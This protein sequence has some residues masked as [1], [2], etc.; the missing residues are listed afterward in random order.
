MT[1]LVYRYGLLPPTAGGDLIAEQISRAHQYAHRLTEIERTRRAAVQAAAPADVLALRAEVDA[2]VAALA[3]ARQAIRATRQRTRTRSETAGDRER[4]T[5]ARAALREAK[6]RWK[7]ARAA[8][9]EDAGAIERRAVIEGEAQAAIREARATSGVFWGTYL[10]V[11]QA[12]EQARRAPVEPH[13]RRWTGDGA[14]SVQCQ[15]GLPVADLVDGGDRR[16]QITA[17][18]EPIPGRKGKPRPRLRLR[19]GSEGRDPVWAEWPVILHRPLPSGSTLLWADVHRSR[20]AGRDEWSAHLTLRLAEDWRREACGTGLLAVDL[21]WRQRGDDILRVGYWRHEDGR[22]EEIL[23]E[24]RIVTGLRKADDL[25]AIRDRHLDELRPWLAAWLH[26]HVSWRPAAQELRETRPWLAV[27]AVSPPDWLA[28]LTEHLALWRS[29]ARFAA[30]A[31]RWREA[32]WDGDGDGYD[33]LVAWRRRD[34]HLWLWEVHQRRGVL[35]RRRDSYR[36]LAAHLAR[37]AGTLVIEEFD[38]RP[39]AARPAAES[40]EAP[41]AV[42]RAHRVVA[43]VSDL[44]TCLRQAFLA[45]GG[46]VVEVSAVDTTRTCHVCASVETWDQAADLVHTCARCGATWD[47]D[48]NATRNLLA[49]ARERLGAA[50]VVDP[51]RVS[52]GA[53]MAG[54][55]TVSGGRWG[56]RK[57]G[58]SQ[59]RPEHGE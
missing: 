2:R 20:V 38:L 23:L 16:V 31:L 33:R 8:A 7:V 57:A 54:T 9:H 42:A 40:E 22:H 37:T 30:L 15:H 14:V 45:R 51:A 27:Q 47:Q 19:V 1:T 35:R 26:E 11:E 58:R 56:R 5:E 43:A 25:R 36:V 28:P 10:R 4:V 18:P 49:R 50:P 3:E 12:A 52:D 59:G 24:P 34:R 41:Q 53:E 44:R 29:P 39:L 46:R 55:P 21:G 17:M 13:F 48:D 6:E 32:R